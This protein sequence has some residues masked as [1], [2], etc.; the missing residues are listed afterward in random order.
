M[1]G[2]TPVQVVLGA[3]RKQTERARN[4]KPIS[5]IPPWSLHMLF[6]PVFSPML[7]LALTSICY[8]VRIISRNKFFPSQVAFGHVLLQ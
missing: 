7:V 1:D 3:I 2:A 4:K 6:S 8:G 5:N